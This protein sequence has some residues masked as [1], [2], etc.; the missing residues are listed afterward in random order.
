MET[1]TEK[2]FEELQEILEKNIDAVRGYRKAAENTDNLA[3]KSY[4]ERK[5]DERSKFNVDLRT[6]I[7]AN[8][9][10]FDEHGS[11]TGTIH[12][13]WMDIKS[14][15]SAN[16]A[17]AM[18]EES[19]R[20]DRAAIDEYNDVIEQ[21]NLPSDLRDLLLQQKNKIEADIYKNNSLESLS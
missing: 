10:D 20:G 8:Y 18:L 7:K 4:F 13:A 21:E 1:I 5:S 12:R 3:L 2:L 14:L 6:K 11:F 16:D 9:P 19:I 17:E 15:F